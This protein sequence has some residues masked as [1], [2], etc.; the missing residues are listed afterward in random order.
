MSPLDDVH[1]LDEPNA[2][3]CGCVWR[4]C[5]EYGDVLIEQCTE[6]WFQG[7]M[8]DR[9]AADSLRGAS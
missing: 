4:R 1:W 7:E 6:H 8:A 3:G 5:E 2:S 9:N